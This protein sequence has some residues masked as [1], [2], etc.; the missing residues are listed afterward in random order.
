MTD[1]QNLK[2]GH[3]F[4]KLRTKTI[5]VPFFDSRCMM[6]LLLVTIGRD[7]RGVASLAGGG[8]HGTGGDWSVIDHT[9][10]PLPAPPLSPPRTCPSSMLN[11]TV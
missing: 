1:F 3:H 11:Y 2:I 5:V 6:W 9:A 10:Q 8:V 4:V 7:V